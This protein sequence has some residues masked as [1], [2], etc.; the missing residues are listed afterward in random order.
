MESE[1]I[2]LTQTHW[3]NVVA[4]TR[5][6]PRR[7]STAVTY[8]PLRHPRHLVD[9]LFAPLTLRPSTLHFLHASPSCSD[10]PCSPLT[11]A[12]ASARPVSSLHV[13]GKWYHQIAR[14][15]DAQAEAPRTTCLSFVEVQSNGDEPPHVQNTR[16]PS[17]SRR[18]GR[19][20]QAA[21]DGKDGRRGDRSLPPGVG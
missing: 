4:C 13:E 19:G 7:G 10:N 21:V 17:A 2:M 18:E 11:S 5:G 15:V 9:H 14:K 3:S 1:N 16:V 6:R 12:P 20:P 8:L